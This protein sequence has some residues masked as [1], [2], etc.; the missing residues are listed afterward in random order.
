M[1]WVLMIFLTLPG[2]GKQLIGWGEYSNL[3]AC[4]SAG[5]HL[6]LPKNDTWRCVQQ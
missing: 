5:S 1:T 6:V 3:V 4:S 2:G